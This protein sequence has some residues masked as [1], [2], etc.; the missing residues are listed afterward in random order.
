MIGAS[1]VLAVH[2]VAM[3]E[4]L[5][6]FFSLLGIFFL[7]TYLERPGQG[8]LLAASAS[9]ALAFLTRYA[10]VAWIIAGGAALL[11][12][13]PR[14]LLGR[15][16]DAL[17]FGV[18]S[19]LPMAIWMVKNASAGVST[20]REVVF[21]PVGTSHVW[22]AIY[23]ASGWMFIPPAAPNVLRL[24]L[25][26]AISLALVAAIAW[27]T[28]DA[29][30]LPT[31][32]PV[33]ALLVVCYAAFLVL[34]ISFLDA[35]TPL[36]DR[37]LI[38]VFVT[39]VIVLLCLLDWGWPFLVRS[40]AVRSVL[41]AGVMAFVAVH[42]LNGTRVMAA[43]YADGWGFSGVEWRRSATLDELR[44]LPEGMPVFSNAPALVYLTTGRVVSPIPAK[45]LLM[46]RQANP[47]FL[48]QI[49]ETRDRLEYSCG[50]VVYFRSLGDQK[51]LPSEQ[52]LKTLLSLDAR[53]DERDGA[54]F[55]TAACLR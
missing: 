27:R 38:P 23:T 16:R 13:S 28:V 12:W 7:A 25:V 41:V 5:F 48:T 55:S 43:S 21:H 54:I 11:L 26:A 45:F 51:S 31:T 37:I 14:P 2:A 40:R 42:L 34:S 9:I 47:E 36:D 1:P 19:T 18:L 46:K 15:L 6:L 52:E 8:A 53:F 30:V 4:P 10:G 50:A 44:K 3:S 49:A 20:G 33:L 39:G 35:N 17:Q 22:Q 24:A 32:V 29:N